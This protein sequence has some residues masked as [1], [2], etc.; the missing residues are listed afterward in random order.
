[1]IVRR[2]VV[3][4]KASMDCLMML[5]GFAC[6]RH[7][8]RAAMDP[9]R[10]RWLL[11]GSERGLLYAYNLS[12]AAVGPS[13]VLLPEMQAVVGPVATAAAGQEPALYCV[14]WNSQL[15]L[16][17]ACSRHATGSTVLLRALPGKPDRCILPRSAVPPPHACSA[18]AASRSVPHCPW[19]AWQQHMCRMPEPQPKSA[20]HWLY[21]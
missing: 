8:L 7:P 17:A 9:S 15:H 12:M 19:P 4:H 14:A 3:L 6:T 5:E 16:V 21:M 2:V 13:G 20:E 1:M 11:L 18:T 10:G